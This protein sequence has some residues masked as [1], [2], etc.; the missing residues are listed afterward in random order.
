MASDVASD[1]QLQVEYAEEVSLHG[2]VVFVD[3]D[4]AGAEP[5]WIRRL[6]PAGQG[7][8]FSTHSVTPGALLALVRD[9]FGSE[10]EAW[11]MGIRGYEFDEFGE[12][13]SDRAAANLDKAAAGLEA[14]L[15][16]TEIREVRPTAPDPDPTDVIP[17]PAD[18]K[19]THV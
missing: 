13:L 11:L 10:P 16:E 15:Q 17:E 4:R 3:A 2:R 12:W 5:F 18:L 6:E 9:L 14:A 1:Y 7:V 8:G 19:V